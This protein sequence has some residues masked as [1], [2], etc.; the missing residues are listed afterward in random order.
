[1]RKVVIESPY[2]RNPDGSV[3]SLH[4]IA[5]NVR[6]LRACMAD[7]LRRDE[8]PIASHAIYTQPGVLDDSKPEERKKGMLAGWAWH[9]RADAI[10]CYLDLGVTPGMRDGC[11]NADRVGCKVEMR[12]LGGGWASWK[13]TQDMSKVVECREYVDGDH[14][15]VAS[16]RDNGCVGFSVKDKG[17]D[18]R[19]L[20]EAAVSAT[21]LRQ[22]AD[23]ADRANE[24]K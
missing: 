10:I 19:L 15:L 21:V 14:V 24:V 18:G 7:C 6:Y 22:L 5:R 17:L 4:T 3:A 13:E 9:E 1:M 23:L 16:I 11:A 8:A 2:G 12:E 20:R